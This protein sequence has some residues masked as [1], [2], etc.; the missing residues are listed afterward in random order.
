MKDQNAL[1]SVHKGCDSEGSRRSSKV[2]KRRVMVRTP[3][4]IPTRQEKTNAHKRPLRKGLKR[5][6][7]T[8]PFFVLSDRLQDT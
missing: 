6:P 5:S 1:E 4:I 3:P 7:D 2:Q 8:S